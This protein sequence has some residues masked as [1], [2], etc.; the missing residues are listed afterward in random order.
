MKKFLILGLFGLLLASC[1]RREE[2]ICTGAR[3]TD[4]MAFLI[5]TT[6]IDTMEFC[7]T[8][9]GNRKYCECEI[10]SLRENFPWETYMVAI[11]NL[12]GE[13]DH[14]AIA[15]IRHDGNCEALLEE[16]NC[17]TCHFTVALEQIDVS[18]TLECVQILIDAGEL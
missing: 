2:T 7:M 17:E 6:I 18:P 13:Q 1:G 8:V 16:L 12:A 9:N 11:D 15:I 14:V 3:I 4:P 10:N 5:R